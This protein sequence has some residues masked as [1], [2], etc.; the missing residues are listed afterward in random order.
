VLITWYPLSAKLALT[1]PTSGGRSVGIVRSRTQA[2]DF[3]K[4]PMNKI[5]VIP[6]MEY[7]WLSQRHNFALPDLSIDQATCSFL[8]IL[9]LLALNHTELLHSACPSVTSSANWTRLSAVVLPVFLT[10]CRLRRCKY[11]L[12]IPKPHLHLFYINLRIIGCLSI[13]VKWRK[14]VLNRYNPALVTSVRDVPSLHA[15]VVHRTWPRVFRV[16]RN[17]QSD[18]CSLCC[19]SNISERLALLH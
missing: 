3:F 14:I 5:N 16:S 2:T 18:I 9:H 8:L 13:Y 19:V 11:P 15:N 6:V 10:R 17:I 7:R 12:R 4:K 1:C